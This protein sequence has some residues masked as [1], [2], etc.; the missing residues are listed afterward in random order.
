MK[1]SLLILIVFTM[2]LGASLYA[3]YNQVIFKD[4]L[5][6][7]TTWTRVTAEN[8][9]YGYSPNPPLANRWLIQLY[10]TTDDIISPLDPLGN[11]TGDDVMVTDALNLNAAQ[12]L[13][14]LNATGLVS[15]G[16]I[17]FYAAGGSQ[18]QQGDKVFLRIF[19]A[20]NIPAAT[21]SIVFTAPYTVPVANAN[22]E[23]DP[24]YAWSPWIQHFVAPTPPDPAV[25]IF[26]GE[27]ATTGYVSQNLSWG[28]GAGAPPTG[29]HVYFGTPAPVYIGDQIGTIYAT[30]A[31]AQSTTYYWQIIPFNGDGGAD[32]LLCP[33][34]SFS[35]RAEMNP[36]PAENPVPANGA[37][38]AMS[39]PAPFMQHLSW[40]PG[41]GFAPS[42]YKII[43]NG[44]PVQDLGINSFFD[45]LIPGPG[46]YTWQVIPYIN[47]GGTRKDLKPVEVTFGSNRT[48]SVRGDAVGCP[49]WSFEVLPYVPGNYTVDLT[50]APTG[51]E[52]FLGA[53]SVGFTPYSAIYPEGFSGTF[54]VQMPGYNWDGPFV[55]SNL[56]GNAAHNFVGTP[57]TYQFIVTSVPSGA[58]IL[59]N[60]LPSGFNTP[61]PFTMGW[62]S[63]ATYSVQMPGYTW[64]PIDYTVNNILADGNVNFDG[65]P[66]TYN[67]MVTSTP[68]GARIWVD[69]IESPFFTPHPFTM[70][71]NTSATYS[72][73]M[74][75]WTFAPL[76]VPVNNIMAD[77]P[78]DFFGSMITY[79]VTITS[80]P[81]G[82][83]VLVGGIPSGLFTPQVFNQPWNTSA[84]YS[85]QM[86]DVVFTPVDFVVNNIIA[87]AAQLFTG[88]STA[89]P[90]VFMIPEWMQA[91]NGMP[92]LIYYN[93]NYPPDIDYTIYNYTDMIT[94]GYQAVNPLA[95]DAN[96]WGVVLNQ[97]AGIVNLQI[98]GIPANTVMYIAAKVG[99]VWVQASPYPYFDTVPGYV[100][101]ALDFG[102]VRGPVG[103]LHSVLPI[104]TPV[105]LSGFDAA[106]TASN[107]VSLTWVTESETEAMGFNIYRSE[108]ANVSD[109][110]KINN[111]IIP[112]TNT[113]QQHTYNVVD[114]ENLIVGNTYYYWLESVDLTGYSVMNGPVNVTLT[115]GTTPPLPELSVM[116]NAY[117]N[118]FRVGDNTTI[119]VD[120]KEGENGTV[121]VYNLLGQVVKTYRVTEGQH[122]LTW[123][124]KGCASGIYFYKLSTPT[125]NSTK[126]LV[127]VN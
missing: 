72:V 123:N 126:K 104:T 74:P 20:Q 48:N 22:V 90:L 73:Q 85:V 18:A 105:T 69:G 4:N 13:L 21:K 1:K 45:I 34:W 116:G 64:A 111:S 114:S 17:R 121:T 40:S 96:T 63:S 108:N 113:S 3:Q 47:D 107:F 23:I 24:T 54:T 76:S 50:S 89:T 95:T 110:Y 7:Y 97:T 99:G 12:Y 49:V 80:T 98:G 11:P 58:A 86:L 71:W 59:V 41:P 92:A 44:G 42:G 5:A 29:Y 84:T 33:I 88:Y 55:I 19:N 106:V 115:G 103:V 43:W 31:L 82:A 91:P 28:P 15:M 102:V 30:G 100:T 93:D 101:I 79:P 56:M 2:L 25:L 10:E 75:G 14:F 65:T 119:S 27:G 78:V 52:V 127:I 46:I 67:V 83:E 94:Q 66:I 16:A 109:S 122:N 87:P 6:P 51:A 8:P 81:S 112:A 38:W 118:P 53:M 37:S 60:G 39:S 57:I 35:T 77:T 61:H 125:V 26:P 32:P 117:P 70:G 9:T 62:N 124:A 68:P 36:N 120:I